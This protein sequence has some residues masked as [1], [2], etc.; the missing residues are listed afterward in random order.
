MGIRSQLKKELMNLE[1]LGLMTADDVRQYVLH[2]SQLVKQH[3]MNMLVRF[4]IHHSKV[5][6]GQPSKEKQLAPK[7]HKL[8]KDILYAK[9]D[10]QSWLTRTA[11]TP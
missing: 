9:K 6:S 2:S 10:V 8:F 1:S 7:R 5:L 4:N 3:G 11:P